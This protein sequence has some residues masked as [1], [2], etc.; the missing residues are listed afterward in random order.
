[1]AHFDA[2]LPGRVHRVIYER[3]VDD[4]AG[5]VRRL[6]EYCGL[7][8]EESC[9]RFYENARAVRTASSEQVR[10][11]D[12]PRRLDQWRHFE[13]WLDPLARSGAGPILACS[14]SVAADL[15]Y[16]AD[17]PPLNNTKSNLLRESIM[18]RSRK[19]KLRRLINAAWAGI[20]PGHIP[21][22][23]DPARGGATADGHGVL[24]EVVV[25][26]QKRSENL[27]DVP[28][29]ITAINTEKLEELH[30]SNF[31][32]YAQLI[33]SVSFQ[34]VGPGFAKIYMRGVANGGDGNHSG[35]LPSVGTYLDEQ[36]ITTIQGT[37]DVHLYDIA[38]V[39]VLAGPQGTLY[40]A[41][42]QAGTVRIISNKPDPGATAGGLRSRQTPY[43]AVIRVIRARA[44]STCR[45]AA[46]R[47]APRRLGG[48]RC[49]LHRQCPRYD[50]RIPVSGI[51]RNNAASSRTTTTTPRPTAPAPRCAST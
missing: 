7:P 9:L 28:L 17:V 8:F 34:S 1:M 2:V 50:A 38:R 26:A 43:P 14:D 15:R 18:T 25:T 30:I 19:R 11:S 29:S 47:R 36:P 10:H 49:R 48:A 4:T 6:L 32:D 23:G 46:A 44:L 39:E 42:S 13:P 31:E 22:G 24:E 40:G 45:S 33:P 35:S 51:T 41:S 20:P 27:Q 37:L 16:A 21:A 5:E 3:L 12:L